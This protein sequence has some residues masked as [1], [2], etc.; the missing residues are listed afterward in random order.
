[1]PPLKSVL[2]TGK[3]DELQDQSP[4]DMIAVLQAMKQNGAA[5]DFK[6]IPKK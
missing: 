3:E 5:I 1:M 4:E 6:F 2:S